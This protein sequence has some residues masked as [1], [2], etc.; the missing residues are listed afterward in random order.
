MTITKSDLEFMEEART[1]FMNNEE[2]STYRDENGDYIALRT[3]STRCRDSIVVLSTVF[4][5]E[6]EGF[7]PEGRPLVIKD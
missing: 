4:V 2:L 7:L 6:F 3:S 5:E 1:V